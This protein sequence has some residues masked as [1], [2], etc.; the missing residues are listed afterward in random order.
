LGEEAVTFFCKANLVIMAIIALLTD[1]GTRDGYTASMKGVIKTICPETSIVD[2]SHDIA[3]QQIAEAKFV[4]WMT[5]RF[6]P[7]GTIFVCVV[8]PGVGTERNI[9]AVRTHQ[10]I[11]LAPDNGLLEMVLSGAKILEAYTISNEKYFL[12]AISSTFHG[13]DIFSPVAA[14]VAN[15]VSLDSLGSSLSLKQFPDCLLSISGKGYYGGSII[16]VDHFG[17]LVTNLRM[18]TRNDATII[19]DDNRIPVKRTYAE[20]EVGE[21]LA[22]TGSSGLLEIAVRN[23]SA[24]QMFDAGYGSKIELQ[25][26]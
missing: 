19:I 18:E 22:L 16:Y 1:F 21:A 4:L 7:T 14:H 10:H 24:E 6:F 12:P 15:G 13:R 11:F 23:G 26:K 2:I 3:P 17:N 8:D 25:V 9:I 20:A 5:Y